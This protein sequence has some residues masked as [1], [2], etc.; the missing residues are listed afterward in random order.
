MDKVKKMWKVLKETITRECKAD[1]DTPYPYWYALGTIP[2]HRLKQAEGFQHISVGLQKSWQLSTYK[3]PM[4]LSMYK[5]DD[6]L[7]SILP[8]QTLTTPGVLGLPHLLLSL[9]CFLCYILISKIIP[10]PMTLLIVFPLQVIV[11]YL[12]II[13]SLLS[14]YLSIA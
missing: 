13:A 2:T 4:T 14:Y 12:I 8:H 11:S 1:N 10:Y 3:K 7:L 5:V 9:L 6:I